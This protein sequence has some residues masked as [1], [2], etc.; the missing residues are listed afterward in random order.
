MSFVKAMFCPCCYYYQL[1]HEIMVKENLNF[2]CLALV[3]V[4]VL[5]GAPE[6]AEMKR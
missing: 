5:S 3:Q 4:G 1:V 6:I 2:G